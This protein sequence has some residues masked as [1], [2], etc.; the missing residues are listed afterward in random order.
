MNRMSCS[1]YTVEGTVQAG[2]AV[3]DQVTPT[4]YYTTVVYYECKLIMGSVNHAYSALPPAL[5]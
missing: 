4:P 1:Q 5:H 3:T 2:M